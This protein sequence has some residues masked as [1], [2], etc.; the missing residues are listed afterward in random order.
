MVLSGMASQ[1]ITPNIYLKV[2]VRVVFVTAQTHRDYSQPSSILPEKKE[3]RK[4]IM[5][6]SVSNNIT[7][8]L[9][10]YY[11]MHLM[12]STIIIIIIIKLYTIVNMIML[13]FLI[14]ILMQVDQS[15]SRI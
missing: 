11:N 3:A 15:S 1:S 9:Y 5:E 14:Q 7:A 2:Q 10:V 6:L 4:R 13:P 8:L 12:Y